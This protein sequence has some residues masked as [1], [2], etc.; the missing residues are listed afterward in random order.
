MRNRNSK[1]I[2]LTDLEICSGSS[3]AIFVHWS[4]DDV[5]SKHDIDL[6]NSLAL[7]F[8][9]VLVVRNLNKSD[10]NSN[11][12]TLDFR[13][14]VSF[15]HRAN[16]GY[17]FGAYKAGLNFVRP[18]S[19]SL[20]EILLMNNS[21]YKLKV[22]LAPLMKKVRDSNFDVTAITNSLED[23]N[24]LQSYFLHLNRNVI[25][26]SDFWDWFENLNPSDNKRETVDQLEVPFAQ[27]I[28][29]FGL[30]TGALWDF[31]Q[32][33]NFYFSPSASWLL[34]DFRLDEGWIRSIA[35]LLRGE[36]VNPTHYM[37]AHLL[38]LGCPFLKKD[39]LRSR[40]FNVGIET[41]S[42]YAESIEIK[43]LVIS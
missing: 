30:T 32:V 17:D 18:V 22:S 3:I 33:L 34:T 14:N 25:D 11:T 10:N 29:S 28:E 39:L 37:W 38:E 1:E 41:W 8:E 5:I 42:R 2:E 15:L 16:V 21:V 26:N 9:K 24:H 13:K 4:K 20:N 12:S 35:L 6:I 7:E 43:E 36:V 31:D 40:D 19:S 27:K 23:Q